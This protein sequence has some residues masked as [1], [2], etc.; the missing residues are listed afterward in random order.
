MAGWPARSFAEGERSPLE[1]ATRSRPLSLRPAIAVGAHAS[2]SG[3]CTCE[4]LHRL[5]AS[6]RRSDREPQAPPCFA[7]PS[8]L[9]LQ[10]TWPNIQFPGWCCQGAARSGV[11]EIFSASTDCAPEPAR[12]PTAELARV[13]EGFPSADTVGQ[14]PRRALA[15]PPDGLRASELLTS[16]VVRQPVR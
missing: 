2:G 16:R 12:S 11:G 4:G 5:P 1:V 13:K 3:T 9:L 14:T 15:P 10:S 8:S 6:S 7:H